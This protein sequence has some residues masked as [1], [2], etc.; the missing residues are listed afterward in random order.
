VLVVNVQGVL[1]ESVSPTLTM[2]P[3]PNSGFLSLS[4]NNTVLTVVPGVRDI[5]KLQALLY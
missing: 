3:M 1:V 5:V 2:R 4:D